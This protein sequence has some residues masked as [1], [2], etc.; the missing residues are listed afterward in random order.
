VLSAVASGFI[1]LGIAIVYADRGTLNLAQIAEYAQA[2]VAS[3]AVWLALGFFVAGFGLKAAMVPFHAWLPDAHPSAPAPV[4]AMLSGILIK[5]SGVYVIARIVFNVLGTSPA[6]GYVL[7]TMGALSMVVGVFLAV[8]Q[9]DFKRLLAYH[10]ISQMGYVL[11]ALGVGV[12]ALAKRQALAS[13]WRGL[14]LLAIG[15]GLFHLVNHAA[16]KSLLFL[17]SGSVVHRTGTRNL[18]KLGGMGVKMPFTSWCTRVGSLSISGVPPFNGFFSKLLIVIAVVWAGHWFL[19]AVTVLVSFMT[20]LSFTKVQRYLIEGEVPKQLEGV[21]ESPIPMLAAMAIL[22]LLCIGLGL[23]LPLHSGV[24]LEPAT[25][26][27]AGEAVGYA[28]SV[29]GG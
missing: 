26:S 12:E 13:N 11:L 16:F 20:L 14:S 24:L 7:M 3:N 27:L 15:A 25:R 5:A 2:G 19:G 1:L 8:G 6:V 4:S 10:S 28:M 22:A 17:S 9:W 18:K 21:R 23:L 29:F